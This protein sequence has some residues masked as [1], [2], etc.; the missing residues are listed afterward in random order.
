LLV[1]VLAL[2][3]S[4]VRKRGFLD[5]RLPKLIFVLLAVYAAVHFWSVYPQL[6][7]VVASHFR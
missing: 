7:G 4:L 3:G 6:P 2:R 5:S 1:G